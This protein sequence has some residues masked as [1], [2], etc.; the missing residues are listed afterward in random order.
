MTELDLRPARA[1]DFPSISRL[2]RQVRINPTGLD[3]R[4]FVVAVDSD[5]ALLGCGQ[6]KPHRGGIVELASIAV[7]PPQRHRGIARLII[8]HLLVLAP[9]PLYLTCRSSLGPFYM[10]WGFGSVPFADM[11]AYYRR[12]TRVMS[13]V[14]SGLSPDDR[15]LVMVL[16]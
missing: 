6:L 9:R 7:V 11:P 16:K 12:L 10:K 8:E 13:I 14:G 15:L 1:Q 3:W 5:G 4:R 2:I